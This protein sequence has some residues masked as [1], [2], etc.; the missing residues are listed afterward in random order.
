MYIVLNL[1]Y[2]PSEH[3]PNNLGA[4]EKL[5]DKV[6]SSASHQKSHHMILPSMNEAYLIVIRYTL[7][8]LCTYHKNNL[9]DRY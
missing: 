9:K 8:I 7:T 5:P 2:E 4:L 1:H 6:L 3:I